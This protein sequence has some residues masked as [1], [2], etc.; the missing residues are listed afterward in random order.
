MLSRLAVE[1]E[2]DEMSTGG[3]EKEEEVCVYVCLF[4]LFYTQP[5]TQVLSVYNIYSHNTLL[6]SQLL[7][8]NCVIQT[9]KTNTT[10]YCYYYSFV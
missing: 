2:S 10:N 6:L 1:Y 7:F 9:N 3:E 8:S 5:E 4:C